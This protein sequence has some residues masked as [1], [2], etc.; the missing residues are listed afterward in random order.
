MDLGVSRQRPLYSRF[1]ECRMVSKRLALSL[2][3]LAVLA[4]GPEV[5]TQS[6]C[7]AGRVSTY[8]PAQC[9][10][11]GKLIPWLIDG[12]GPFH[13]IMNVEARWWLNA[14]L[15]SGWP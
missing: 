2:T 8:H 4:S 12:A 3:L 7:G 13:S 9:N 10:A 15:V 5:A 6:T 1:G 11:S 14:P